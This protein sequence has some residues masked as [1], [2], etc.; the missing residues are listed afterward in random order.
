MKRDV[1][2]PFKEIGWRRDPI[3]IWE[4]AEFDI[5]DA[6]PDAA[7]RAICDAVNGLNGVREGSIV[8]VGVVVTSIRS[9]SRKRKSA[10]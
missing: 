2:G 9:G 3:R 6:N 8:S 10:R 5:N 7:H 4:P 1:E